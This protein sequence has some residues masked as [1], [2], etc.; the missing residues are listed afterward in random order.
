MGN[1]VNYFFKSPVAALLT[2]C[3]LTGGPRGFSHGGH[4][5]YQIFYE[6]AKSSPAPAGS[7]KPTKCTLSLKK[8][9]FTARRRHFRPQ[10]GFSQ[11][12]CLRGLWGGKYSDPR[13]GISSS[14]SLSICKES[15]GQQN[16]FALPSSLWGIKMAASKTWGYCPPSRA[17][18]KPCFSI[19]HPIVVV[20]LKIGK[21]PG[22]RLVH[23]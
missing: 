11:S 6:F 13:G 20:W 23:F 5:P 17:Q 22:I 12:Q 18:G 10:N 15:K 4:S 9:M 3:R 14:M 2:V 7:Q 16:I 19:F 21:A 1:F 8:N